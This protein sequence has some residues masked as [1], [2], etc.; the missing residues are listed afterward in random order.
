MVEGL[1]KT[2]DWTGYEAE[3]L[4]Q[5]HHP[6]VTVRTLVRKT[7]MEFIRRAVLW[8]GR[9][10]GVEGWIEALV[11]AMNKFIVFERLWELQRKPSLDQTYQSLDQGITEAWSEF[12]SQ[13]K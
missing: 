7:C 1:R 8:D 3:L 5:A 12:E 6:H 4:F 10:D 2:I 13:H 9:K 11:Q